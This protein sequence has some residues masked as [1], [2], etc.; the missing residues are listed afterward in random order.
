MCVWCVH[1]CVYVMCM[2]MYVIYVRT[3]VCVCASVYVSHIKAEK[4]EIYHEHADSK[5]C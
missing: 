2:Y 3:Y 1:A 5:M 4:N